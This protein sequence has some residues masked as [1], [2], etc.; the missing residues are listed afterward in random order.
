MTKTPSNFVV[1]DMTFSFINL[2][3]GKYYTLTFDVD[4]IA[5]MGPT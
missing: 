1:A 5:T 2:S 4:G 3:P